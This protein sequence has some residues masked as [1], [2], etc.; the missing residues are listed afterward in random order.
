MYIVTKNQ[1]AK[2]DIIMFCKDRVVHYKVPR[3]IHF[4][5]VLLKTATGKI[6]KT[7]VKINRT[8]TE[9]NPLAISLGQ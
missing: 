4:M 8:N 2:E 1:I 9:K 7:P 5:K 3:I 6:L